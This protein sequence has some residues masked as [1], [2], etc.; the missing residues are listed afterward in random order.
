MCRTGRLHTAI[1]GKSGAKFLV[2]RV[3]HSGEP[4]RYVEN[5]REPPDG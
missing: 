1:T 2:F 4:M 3:H 5:D